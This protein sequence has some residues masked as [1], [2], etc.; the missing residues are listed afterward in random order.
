MLCFVE[1][2]DYVI[3][4]LLYSDFFDQLVAVKANL[5]CMSSMTLKYRTDWECA[6]DQETMTNVY[7]AYACMYA[8][9]AIAQLT[10]A[11]KLK[12]DL[13]HCSTQ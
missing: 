12:D 13:T 5:Q 3:N 8:S 9:L 7:T 1:T 10:K 11:A 4:T 6:T 2:V